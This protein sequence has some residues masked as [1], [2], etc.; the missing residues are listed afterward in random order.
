[1]PL[2]EKYKLLVARCSASQS[3]SDE[4]CHKFLCLCLL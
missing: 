3:F 2:S 4:I 1:V